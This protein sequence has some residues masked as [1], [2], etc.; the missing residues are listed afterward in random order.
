MAKRDVEVI[1]RAKDEAAKAIDSVS[2]ALRTLVSSQDDLSKSAGKT[3]TS[4][5]RLGSA[6]ATLNKQFAGMT[7][8]Q[9]AVTTLDKATVSTR[10]C[11]TRLP[12]T[13]PI[14]FLT[15]ISLIRLETRAVV[16]FV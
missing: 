4:L 1:I 10:N 9:R 8:V 2:K 13:A 14:T 5:T 16:R 11:Q 6:V 7:A 12:R 15:P 3:D